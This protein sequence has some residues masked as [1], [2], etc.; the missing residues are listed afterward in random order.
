MRYLFPSVYSSVYL[1][2]RRETVLLDHTEHLR[3]LPCGNNMFVYT[4][5]YVRCVCVCVCVCLVS[6]LNI[7]RTVTCSL[8]LG[9]LCDLLYCL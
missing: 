5:I 9:I 6:L 8:W 1:P 4:H 7:V 3:Q 2:L